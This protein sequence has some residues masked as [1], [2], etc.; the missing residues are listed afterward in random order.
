MDSATIY[1]TSFKL[2]DSQERDYMIRAD[3]SRLVPIPIDNEFV[4]ME[5]LPERAAVSSLIFRQGSNQE[6]IQSQY[7]R[8]LVDLGS[9]DER[10]ADFLKR[11]WK[12]NSQDTHDTYAA[13]DFSHP[14]GFRKHLLISW[15]EKHV[16][17]R[18]DFTA[19]EPVVINNNLAPSGTTG[20]GGDHWAVPN[21][22]DVLTGDFAY[23]SS[24]RQVYPATSGEWAMPP[25]GWISFWDDGGD[26]VYGFTFSSG[27]GVQIGEDDTTHFKFTLPAGSST[28]AFQVRKPRPDRAYDAIRALGEKPIFT[29]TIQV[30]QRFT[31]ANALL[32]YI[33]EY[34]NTGPGQATQTMIQNMLP[35]ELSYIDGSATAGGT[36]DPST[37]SLTWNIGVLDADGSAQQVSFRAQVDSSVMDGYDIVNTAR[38]FCDELY[39]PVESH[40]IATVATPTITGVSPK[41]GGNTGTVMVTIT[42]RNLDPAAEVAMVRLGE[43]SI[44]STAVSGYSDGTELMAEFDIKDKAEGLWDIIVTNPNGLTSTSEPESANDF[45]IVPGGSHKLWIEIVGREE[46][47]VG[48]P[49]TYIIQ[50]GN[51]GNID[52]LGVP[53]WIVIQKMGSQYVTNWELDAEIIPPPPIDWEEIPAHFRTDDIP[54][55]PIDWEEIPVHVETDDEIILPLLVPVIPPGVTRELKLKVTITPPLEPPPPG[56]EE[57]PYRASN[58]VPHVP[59][60]IRGFRSFQAVPADNQFGVQA[61]FTSPLFHSPL[62]PKMAD[63]LEQTMTTIA[64]AFVDFIIPGECLDTFEKILGGEAGKAIAKWRLD[65]ETDFYGSLNQYEYGAIEGAFW[66]MG[67]TLTKGTG[68]GMVIQT[69]KFLRGMSSCLEVIW[70]TLKLLLIKLVFSISPEDKFGPVGYDPDVAN[71]DQRQRFVQGKRTFGYR[72]DF[73]NKE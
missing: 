71:P 65:P 62:D 3:T 30:D 14:T 45:E 54:P 26:E 51:S 35:P 47:R 12:L 36:Y 29:L 31:G 67:E 4:K 49:T 40:T 16:E 60:V 38:I 66:C 11:N 13:F 5:V 55:P 2:A 46:N 21:N 69:A 20:D 53:L 19:P 7:D 42:G 41:E 34:A 24:Y 72:I 44:R 48:C 52:A 23:P 8:Y 64:S 39:T 58:R 28:I 57:A 37:H 10:L 32:T 43:E 1:G 73:W 63:C 61:W 15:S 50:Y 9:E 33:I 68:I 27:Y 56:Y 17:V 18:C 25:G 70:D 22:P 59:A 6:L